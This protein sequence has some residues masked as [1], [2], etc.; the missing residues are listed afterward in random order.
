MYNKGTSS[1]WVDDKTFQYVFI[2]DNNTVTIIHPKYE[3]P[4]TIKNSITNYQYMNGGVNVT[5][6]DD[7]KMPI[8]LVF[9]VVNSS[10]Q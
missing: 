7:S 4:L 9:R 8:A 2:L 10:R 1:N 6:K 5:D 3:N